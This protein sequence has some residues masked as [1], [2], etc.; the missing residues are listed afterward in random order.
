M[1]IKDH[2][3]SQEIFEI[4]ET[5]INGILKTTPIP[6]NIDKYYES[7]DYI[8]HHQDTGSLKQKLY[9]FLQSFN[10]NY[11]RNIVIAETNKI[12]QETKSN[13]YPRVLDY[14]CGAGE[15]IKQI[16]KD[17]E[18]FGLEP[19]D[20][21]RNAA[22]LKTSKTKFITNLNEIKNESIDVITMWHVFEHIENQSEMLSL[23]HQKLKLN[24]CLIIAVPNHTSY[25]AKYYK[26]FWAAY[27]VPR[28][29][30]HFSKSGMEKLMNNQNWKLEKIKPLLLDSYYISTLSEKYKKNPLFWFFGGIHGAISNIK[31]SKSG[32]FSSLIYIIRKIEK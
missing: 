23:F 5:E 6:E 12:L 11:K 1:K 9:K 8:S 16:E 22:Q 20:I 26:E 32:E 13:E 2:F 21:A 3:L 25:D 30:F 27:D 10:L 17:V 7:E 29:I 19:N 24:G 14:G 15:F 31:A 18:T 28:H 4:Q